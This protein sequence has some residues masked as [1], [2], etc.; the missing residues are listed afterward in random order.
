MLLGGFDARLVS[1]APVSLP[2]KKAQ[3]LLAY[4]GI[5]PGQSHPRDKLAALLW[6]E[7]SDE[8]ARGG[9]RHALV[10]LRRAL[11][12]AHPPPLRI[13]GQT[14]ALNSVG[15]EVDVV[16]FE[17]RVAEGTPQ[18]L[19]QA[20][21]L[22][23]GDLL[24]GFSVNEPLFEEWL[25]AERERLREM[26]LAA[27]ARLL[28]HQSKAAGTERAIQTAVRLLGLD[29]LQETVHR[30]LMHLY[31]RQG[32]RGAALKQY[33]VCVGVLQRELGME[34]EAETKQL[35]QDLLRRPAE[36]VKTPDAGADHRAHPT[37]EVG[38]APPDLAAAETPLFGRQAEL[39]RLRQVL[40]EA[41]QGH[42]H[43]ATVMGEA[44]IGKTQLVSTLAADAVAQGCRVLI[45]RCHES[46][47]I[48]PFG[49]W[50]D[51]CRSGQVSTDEEILGALHPTR[52]AELARLLPESSTAGLP[53]A[54]EGALLLFESV[55]ELIEQV[56]ARQPLVIVLEDLHWADEMSL[57]LLAF[58][59]RRIAAWPALL[60]A[61]AR[62]EELADASMARRTLEELARAAH[63]MPVALSPLSRP[64]IALLVRAL[65]RVGSDAPTVAHVEERIWAMSEGNPFVAVE[66]VRSLDQ[67]GLRDEAREESGALALP[68]SVRDLVARRMDRLSPRGQQL[69][70]VAAVIG[71]QFEFTLLRSASG[72]EERDAAEAVEEMVRCHVLQAIGTQLDF[73]HDR[74]REVA[75][76]R[77]LPP[78]RRLLHGAVAEALEAV[79]AGTADAMETL[80]RDRPREQTEQLAY[81]ALRGEVWDKALRYCGQAGAKAAGRVAD[82]EAVAFF[83]QALATL[84]NLP[85]TQE[86]R[87][88]A[89][90]L[91]VHLRNSLQVLGELSR[92]LDCLRRAEALAEA[93][94]DRPRLVEIA[95]T[96]S[97]HFWAVADQDRA[98]EG[99]R[100]S[101]ALAVDL[102]D[103]SWQARG[104][105]LVGRIHHVMGDYRL[106]IDVL[107]ESAEAL[108]G[109][110]IS[111][112]ART[113]AGSPNASGGRCSTTRFR[114][115]VSL[116]SAPWPTT[117]AGSSVISRANLALC[118]AEVGEFA[119][120]VVRGE[121]ARRIAEEIDHPYSRIAA[122]LGL[123][124]VWV[125]QGEFEKAVTVF[126]RGFRLCEEARSPFLFPWIAAHWAYASGLSGRVA[127]A[128]PLLEQAVERAAGMRLLVYQ[129][130][131]IAWLSEIT[132]LGGRRDDAVRL[133]ERALDLARTHKERGEE[134]WALR[135]L[136]Q[137]HIGSDASGG[138]QA[139]DLYQQ[140]LVI[141]YELGMRPLVANCHLGLGK[142]SALTGRLD[143][144][145]ERLDTAATMFRD[146][147]MRFWLDQAETAS[148]SLA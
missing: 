34:P 64:D 128:L 74:V 139:E 70:A 148:N 90:D 132:L 25:V 48:L 5:R 102:N 114:V 67:V 16:T 11:A 19:E 120:A 77:L 22:Y 84:E 71:R 93:L 117:T 79:G 89:I 96:L 115:A 31:G 4:L 129:S 100:R 81:H 137:I 33:Q 43:V 94:G 111:S 44:G 47:S 104:R 20:A 75:Y 146:M 105:Y 144:A 69:A 68:A 73:S 125:R 29:P 113:S 121:E 130:Q 24:L 85:E 72:L 27:L 116:S 50:V 80:S 62:H 92:G 21:E 101:L 23:R 87:K 97:S 123:G 126:E 8:Q 18:A 10:V 82:R 61:T 66:A 141:A 99:A 55:A 39:G 134:A 35:Y 119:E 98:L 133:G 56:A 65:T 40:G 142:L 46:D 53:R 109:S 108:K 28:G 59:S 54:S 127:E 7:K 3:A 118:L 2:T 60:V 58:V 36:A 37:R 136:G 143:Q 45:G 52:R 41:I 91:L 135:L 110:G 9:L 6:G 145:R 51:A 103:P 140:A 95:A 107:R 63:E 106:A 49:P 30:T 14:L 17:R 32:R 88:H 124:G 42:G 78:R 38:P 13:E 131:R 12:D 147:N 83:E 138:R 57:R 112:S 86:M 1:G 122:C 76:G 26:A 15:V